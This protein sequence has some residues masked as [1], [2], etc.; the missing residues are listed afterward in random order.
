MAAR[1][2]ELIDARLYGY[3]SQRLAAHLRR[4]LPGPHPRLLG[5]AMLRLE[6]A[7]RA[8][9][10]GHEIPRARWLRLYLT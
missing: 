4:R 7:C 1:A 2:P 6:R 9:R 5:V 8:V 10:T 3:P